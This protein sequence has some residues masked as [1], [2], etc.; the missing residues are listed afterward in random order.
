MQLA[1]RKQTNY[2]KRKQFC[3]NRNYHW[4]YW[5]LYWR[6][7]SVYNSIEILVEICTF[8]A[9]LQ[10]KLNTS[11]SCQSFRLTAS[12]WIFYIFMFLVNFSSCYGATSIHVTSRFN[13]PQLLEIF[14][15]L[16]SK[17]CFVKRKSLQSFKII[18][19]KKRLKI[20]NL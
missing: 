2:E 7:C 4:F 16:K 9:K 13:S 15:V 17:F 11:S 12:I 19:Y 14:L 3:L 1:Y 8:E 18:S 10:V 20:C 5:I 6:T